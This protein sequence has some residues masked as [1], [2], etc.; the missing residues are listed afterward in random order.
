MHI[1]K[2]HT[3]MINRPAH[4]TVRQCNRIANMHKKHYGSIEK[5]VKKM[6]FHIK[7]KH[8]TEF[9]LFIVQ[10]YLRRFCNEEKRRFSFLGGI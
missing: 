8:G 10:Y 2:R 7:I 3:Y 4:K 5:N 1:V 6:L 9:A